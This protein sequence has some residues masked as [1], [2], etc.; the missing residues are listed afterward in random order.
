MIDTN[1]N[2]KLVYTEQPNNDLNNHRLMNVNQI[3][4]HFSRYQTVKQQT[5][6]IIIDCGFRNWLSDY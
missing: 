5:R 3:W 6:R 2:Q 1:I 4:S